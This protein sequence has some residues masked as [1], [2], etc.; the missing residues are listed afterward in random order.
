MLGD[1]VRLHLALF[2]M[3][4]AMY[5]WHYVVIWEPKEPHVRGVQGLNNTGVQTRSSRVDV[6]PVFHPS[7]LRDTRFK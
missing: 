7:L 4:S 2:V 3:K 5:T 6:L 1:Q